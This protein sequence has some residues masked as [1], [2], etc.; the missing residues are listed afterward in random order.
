MY[1][2]ELFKQFS[3]DRNIKQITVKGYNIASNHY[4]DF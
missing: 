1:G 2:A 4:I 3:K